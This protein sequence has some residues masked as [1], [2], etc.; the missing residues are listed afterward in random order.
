MARQAEAERRNR[1]R[2]STPNVESLAATASGEASGM[3]LAH[4]IAPELRNLQSVV[5][6]GVDKTR[7]WCSRPR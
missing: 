3:T 7:R 5:E 6:K 4:P 1:P 2:S